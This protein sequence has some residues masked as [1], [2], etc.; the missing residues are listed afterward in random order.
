MYP[1]RNIFAVYPALGRAV[2]R[3]AVNVP[4]G[5]PAPP[6]VKIRVGTP[7]RRRC[8]SSPAAM[9]DDVRAN[10]K[11]NPKQIQAEG[12]RWNSRSICRRPGAARKPHGM[13]AGMEPQYD[14][15]RGDDTAHIGIAPSEQSHRRH[16]DAHTSSSVA[17]RR[18]CYLREQMQGNKPGS[19]STSRPRSWSTE[20]AISDT[21]S[22]FP[23]MHRTVLGL[24]AFTGQ[25]ARN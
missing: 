19:A 9:A 20:A 4:S 3:P 21:R 11:A 1:D 8:S 16:A 2:I 22:N 24:T 7:V 13:L 17:T 14:P 15:V 5:S 23:T 10:P 12:A 6:L 25:L 18:S